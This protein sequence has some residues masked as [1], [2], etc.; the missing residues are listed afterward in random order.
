MGAG[1][2][3]DDLTTQLTAVGR[4]QTARKT[5]E[6]QQQQLASLAAEDLQIDCASVSKCSLSVVAAVCSAEGLCMTVNQ[7]LQEE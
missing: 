7:A 4:K 1:A 5:A 3:E 6:F 2:G